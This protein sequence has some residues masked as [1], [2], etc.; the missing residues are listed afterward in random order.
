MQVPN[1]FTVNVFADNV[2]PESQN[3]RWLGLTPTGDVLYHF[4]KIL[5]YLI[6]WGRD[7]A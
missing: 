5:L 3:P 4:S 6:G 1:G 2:L 7:V